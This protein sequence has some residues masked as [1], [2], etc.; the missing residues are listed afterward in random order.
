MTQPPQPAQ[1]AQPRPQ[2]PGLRVDALI[3]QGAFSTVWSGAD[4][5]GRPVAIKVPTGPPD[6]QGLARGLLERHVLMAVRH[7]H[8]VSLRDVVELDDGRSALVF[9]LVR[10]ILLSA[11][12]GARGHLQPGETVT[13]VSPVCEAVAALH[14]A[15]GV[16]GDISARNVMVRADGRPVLLDLGASHI[17]GQGSGDVH[18]TP[19][20]VAPE[21]R[22]GDVPTEASDVFSLGALAWFCLT[23]NGAPD[24]LLRLD[25]DTVRSHVG[26]ELGQL[27]ARC[28]DPDPSL[29]PSSGEVARLFFDAAA[30]EPVEVVVGGDDAS[31]LTHRLRAAAASEAQARP[32]RS[33]RWPGIPGEAMGRLAGRVP[34]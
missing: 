31:A 15:G 2:V 3:G 6:E 32:R 28:I 22:S 23:G 11:L 34:G 1:P 9:D 12:V 16:H 19:G 5:T 18:G 20:F 7:E 29:R 24:T 26:P 8:L 14:A 17:A 21:V 10:G 13:V 27:V 25:P 4:A 30:P 33:R